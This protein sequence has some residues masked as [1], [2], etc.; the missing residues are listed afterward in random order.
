MKPA[1]DVAEKLAAFINDLKAEPETR[2]QFR[3]PQMFSRTPPRSRI[4]PTNIAPDERHAA[5]NAT[6]LSRR[7]RQAARKANQP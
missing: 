5:F 3:G 4:R 6:V 7:Q 2:P 1:E